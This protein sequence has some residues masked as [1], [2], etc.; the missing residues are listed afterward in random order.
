MFKIRTMTDRTMTDTRYVKGGAVVREAR[1][2]M[3]LS[4]EDL[5]DRIDRDRSYISRIETGDI[6]PGR[7]TLILLTRVL[8]RPFDVM[9]WAVADPSEADTAELPA[10]VRR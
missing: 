2:A 3:G 10:E 5:A 1:E 9:L 7:D 4:R 6:A 8:N